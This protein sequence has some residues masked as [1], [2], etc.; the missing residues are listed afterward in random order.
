[1]YV[2]NATKTVFVDEDEFLAKKSTIPVWIVISPFA[3]YLSPAHDHDESD[4]CLSCSFLCSS[5]WEKVQKREKGCAPDLTKM[6]VVRARVTF[7]P[8][9]KLD[10]NEI[11]A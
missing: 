5:R 2:A 8:G 6:M 11:S 9:K 7:R 3:S 1:M 10:L 4:F